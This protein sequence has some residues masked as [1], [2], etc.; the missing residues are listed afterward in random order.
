MSTI[1]SSPTASPTPTFN[2]QEFPDLPRSTQ[3]EEAAQKVMAKKQKN[4]DKRK[5]EKSALEGESS[6]S[7][8]PPLGEIPATNMSKADQLMTANLHSNSSGKLL[9]DESEEPQDSSSDEAFGVTD[10]DIT[11]NASMINLKAASASQASSTSAPPSTSLGVAGSMSTTQSVS[12]IEASVTSAPLSISTSQFGSTATSQS[13]SADGADTTSAR[14]PTST[15]QVRSASTQQSHS[16]GPSGSTSTGPMI[17]PGELNVV[18]AQLP[19]TTPS[20]PWTHKFGA[21]EGPTKVV[22]RLPSCDITTSPWDGR[23]VI[24]P[25]CG[26]YSS[27]RYCCIDHLL[28]DS[29]DHW[30]VDCMKYTCNHLCD[31]STIHPR[32][33]SC[34]PLIPNICGWNTPERH[35]QAVYHAHS[36]KKNG[37]A[38]IEGDYF[39]FSDAEQWIRAGTPPM[40]VWGIRR[41]RGELLV[42][43]TFDDDASPNSLKDRFNRLLNAALFTGASNALLLN[44]LFLMIR[45]NLIGKDEWDDEILDSVVF[46][47]QYE[48]C[49][50]IPNWI[51]NN[52]RHACPHQWFG[53]PIDQCRDRVCNGEMLHPVTRRPMLPRLAIKEKTD[54]LERRYWILRVARVY[55]PNIPD[56][57]ARMRGVGFDFV[58]PE[59]RRMYC[60][61]RE[62]EGYPSGTMEIEGAIWVNTVGGPRCLQAADLMTLTV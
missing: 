40:Q 6:Q 4:K 35:R 48:F 60:M 33:V 8:S 26:P 49:Y 62:W 22:C 5:E 31:A 47:F 23:T 19:A 61:G 39:I 46:Q 25:G 56:Q 44:Y 51:T 55:H 53:T 30:G 54:E 32:Q 43:V 13:I 34:P 16:A 52:K 14:P 29:T 37:F 1:H 57:G 3:S 24:C 10:E 36:S 45:E 15:S 28:A 17:N 50:E 7:S 20:R 58:P 9:Q 2:E 42:V 59:N 21:F 38:E 11:P 27:I 12:A 41:A 18:S